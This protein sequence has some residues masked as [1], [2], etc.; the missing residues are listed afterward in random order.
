MTLTVELPQSVADR[1]KMI[2]DDEVNLYAV[3]VIAESLSLPQD[4][5]VVAVRQALKSVAE[6]RTRPAAEFFAEHRK[7]FPDTTEG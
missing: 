7:R 6:R 3:A 2:P 4:D 5:E 1:L